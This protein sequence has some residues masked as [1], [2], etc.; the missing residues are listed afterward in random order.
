MNLHCMNTKKERKANC[1]IC[2]KNDD[3]VPI[4][5][6]YTS[7]ETMKKAG[8]GRFKLGGCT[9]MVEEDIVEKIRKAKERGEVYVSF[10]TVGNHWHCMRNNLDF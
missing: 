3:V 1:P 7:K 10:R 5:Y 8:E 6:G 9:V 4:V 2:G